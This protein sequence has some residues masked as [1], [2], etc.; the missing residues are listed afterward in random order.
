MHV[1][2]YDEEES[3][4]AYD[5]GESST[6]F[7]DD[8]L[9]QALKLTEK[10]RE[11]RS[12]RRICMEKKANPITNGAASF[13]E[14][15][16]NTIGI[17]LGNTGNLNKRLAQ[18][19]LIHEQTHRW[20]YKTGKS[21]DPLQYKD[22]PKVY[23]KLMLKEE[24]AAEG[25]AIDHLM[26]LNPSDSFT[27][28]ELIYV[29]AYWKGYQEGYNALKK[30]MPWAE[31]EQEQ[32]LQA[33]GRAEGIKRGREALFQAFKSGEFMPSTSTEDNP[34]TYPEYYTKQWY[35]AWKGQATA[36]IGQHRKEEILQQRP[37]PFLGLQPL[38]IPHSRQTPS[39]Q[40]Y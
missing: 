21:A 20:Y 23:V 27:A 7:G 26:E 14:P 1:P 18:K 6:D 12:R 11:R 34:E 32:L 24:A 36:R 17:G 5:E 35:A 31:K 38:R 8:P 33:A 39:L 16:S 40:R 15:L 13:Y 37:L 3:P 25:N 28:D 29:E 4:P 22:R 2:A 10:G 9:F 19:R 30:M